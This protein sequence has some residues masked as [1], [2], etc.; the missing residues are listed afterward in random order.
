MVEPLSTTHLTKRRM[1]A[2]QYLPLIVRHIGT[3]ALFVVEHD[4][5]SLHRPLDVFEREPPEITKFGRHS[6]HHGVSGLPEMRMP[7]GGAC[8]SRRAATFMPSPYKSSPS[9]MT[10]PT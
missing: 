6:V 9:M 2:L 10:S 7:P 5:K 1:T 4:L 3:L 8:P